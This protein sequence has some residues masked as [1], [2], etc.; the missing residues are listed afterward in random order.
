MARKLPFVFKRDTLDLLS[1]GRCRVIWMWGRLPWTLCRHVLHV[2][3]PHPQSALQ[4]HPDF[5]QNEAGESHGVSPMA[6]ALSY[7]VVHKWARTCWGGS[8]VRRGMKVRE[9]SQPRWAS[10][11]MR[12]QDA[13]ASP[14][15]TG[16]PQA[17]P[18]RSS[19]F[20]HMTNEG[21]N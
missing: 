1:E 6:L 10:S 16:R 17:S 5:N 19:E 3:I 11:R 4:G 15:L 13:E 18:S 20:P 21:V 8:E 12:T 14:L 7:L 2:L 9:R